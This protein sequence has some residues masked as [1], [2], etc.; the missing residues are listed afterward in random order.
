MLDRYQRH[1][2]KVLLCG[3]AAAGNN[4]LQRQTSGL[5]TAKRVKLRLKPPHPDATSCNLCR[6]TE[7]PALVRRQQ[8]A[9]ARKAPTA[10]VAG[11]APSSRAAR[12]HAQAREEWPEAATIAT[13]IDMPAIDLHEGDAQGGRAQSQCAAPKGSAPED[14]TT[15]SD[16]RPLG[17]QSMRSFLEEIEKR[18]YGDVQAGSLL[19]R[20]IALER[21]LSIVEP[22]ESVEQRVQSIDERVRDLGF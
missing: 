14:N 21:V 11:P 17:Q 15:V 16:I 18:V 22:Q 4:E 12:A 20:C 9:R 1:D 5:R 8:P 13:A 19:P 3:D 7:A 2:L 6:T 10:F